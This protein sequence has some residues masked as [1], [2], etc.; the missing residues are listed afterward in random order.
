[1]SAGLTQ[2]Q[3]SHVQEKFGIPVDSSVPNTCWIVSLD[4]R[5]VMPTD[6]EL[7]QIRSFC[8][9]IVSYIYDES[10]QRRILANKLPMASDHNTIILHKGRQ[11]GSDDNAWFYRKM[12]YSDPTFAPNPTHV[13]YDPPSLMQ[14]MSRY[15]LLFPE[16]WDDWKTARPEIFSAM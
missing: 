8:E 9:Y 7:R 5:S 15:E 13:Q 10:H 1:M 16:R 6:E 12:S 2:E 3:R 14:L 4:V 11:Y